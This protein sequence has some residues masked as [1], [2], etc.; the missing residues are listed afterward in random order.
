VTEAE[1]LERNRIYR[2][3]AILWGAACTASPP[4][5][6]LRVAPLPSLVAIPDPPQTWLDSPERD[7]SA[8]IVAAVFDCRGRPIVHAVV[9]VRPVIA[10][11]VGTATSGASGQ[12]ALG[13]LEPGQVSIQIRALGYD[14]RVLQ[15][16][17]RPGQMDTMRIRLSGAIGL[18]EDCICPDGRSMGGRCCARRTVE[19]CSV[20]D[21]T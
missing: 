15:H 6:F 10:P 11:H 18:I 9:T 8:A 5:E 2:A 1:S 7:R 19:T 21:S 13:P 3:I 14:G 17:L 12:L 20:A 4:P 16:T